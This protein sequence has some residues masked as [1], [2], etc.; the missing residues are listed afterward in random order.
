MSHG[1]HKPRLRKP[2]VPSGIGGSVATPQVLQVAAQTSKAGLWL[3]LGIHAAL[4]AA[5][6]SI[7]FHEP[8][9][10]ASGVGETTAD[11]ESFEMQI[12]A[13]RKLTPLRESVTPPK[14]TS[15]PI[16]P[17][18]KLVIAMTNSP[19]VSEWPAIEPIAPALPVQPTVADSAAE[20]S[21]HQSP[22]KSTVRGSKSAGKKATGEKKIRA[23]SSRTPPKLIG[24]A[25]PRYPSGAK[26]SKKSGKVGVLV[27]VQANGSAAA[28]RIYRSSGNEQL[29]QA[30]VT[31]AQS[32]KFTKT[33]SLDPGETIAV[34]VQV[35]FKL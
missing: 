2:P 21:T 7:T 34:V 26:S 13:A 31:A 32:W 8:S 23:R 16:A 22:T 3:S 28:T 35:T 25:P 17:P 30:A 11:R 20:N 24:G 33:P 27:R 5:A 15:A 14:L 19:S 18:R 4:I 10:N 29:D 6:C 1:P 12:A 9:D